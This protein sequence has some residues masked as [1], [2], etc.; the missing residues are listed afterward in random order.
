MDS[1]DNQK[2]WTVIGQKKKTGSG[3][4]RAPSGSNTN[5]PNVRVSSIDPKTLDM[6]KLFE[7]ESDYVFDT[8]GELTN[9]IVEKLANVS[10][11]DSIDI[12]GQLASFLISNMSDVLDGAVKDTKIVKDDQKIVIGLNGYIEKSGGVI[13]N[14]NNN[15]EKLNTSLKVIHEKKHESITN[16]KKFLVTCGIDEVKNAANDSTPPPTKATTMLSY[17]DAFGSAAS[18]LVVEKPPVNVVNKMTKPRTL[19]VD[20][21]IVDISVPVVSDIKNTIGY[22]MSYLDYCKVFVIE[23]N[24]TVFTTGPG[25]FVNLKNSSGQT[26]HAKRCLN[27]Q[28]CKYKNCKYYHDPC[29]VYD[30]YST[31]RNFALS[32][33]IQLLSGIKNNTDLLENKSVRQPNYVRDLVQLGGI[34]LLRAAQIKALYFCNRK[35]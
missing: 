7:R 24:G 16:I 35:M 30:E 34:I 33:V 1:K 21:G 10:K 31:E 27:P 8:A 12:L 2:G 20:T 17:R 3:I 22:T 13:E 26:K 14:I 25:N 19:M 15:M 23:M 32:Y 11:E 4:F 5:M 6:D 29:I 9:I 28:P 18:E